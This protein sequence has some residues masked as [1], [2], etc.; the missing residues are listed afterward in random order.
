M[1]AIW[2][3]YSLPTIYEGYIE[4]N[5]VKGK[6]TRQQHPA[7][8]FDRYV[9]IDIKKENAF[10]AHPGVVSNESIQGER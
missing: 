5:I 1:Q 9:R 8:A 10:R 4:S 3:L 2:M 7:T 6:T